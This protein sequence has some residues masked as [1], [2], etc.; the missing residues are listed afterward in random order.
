[1]KNKEKIIHDY[2]VQKQAD[3]VNEMSFVHK[4]ITVHLK[5]TKEGKTLE[6]LL[7]NHFKSLKTAD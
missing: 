7:I 3:S 1:M 5:F 2:D 4:G 6:E